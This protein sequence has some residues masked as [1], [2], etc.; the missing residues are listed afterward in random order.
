MKKYY[1]NV[2]KI[3]T[4]D[5]DK[6]R[7]LCRSGTQNFWDVPDFS[8]RLILLFK[9]KTRFAC[10]QSNRWNS[11]NVTGYSKY[12][13]EHKQTYN[14]LLMFLRIWCD[15]YWFIHPWSEAVFKNPSNISHEYFAKIV[16]DVNLKPLTILGKRCMVNE[17]RMRLCRWI[18]LSS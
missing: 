8:G 7:A 17:S 9:K 10:F 6:L 4:S 11:E 14:I 18:Q 1:Y 12:Y 16:S 15:Q 3:A 5:L 13:R 2:V